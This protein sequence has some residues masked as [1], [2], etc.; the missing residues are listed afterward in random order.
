MLKD[1]REEALNQ[2]DEQYDNDFYEQAKEALMDVGLPEDEA[3]MQVEDF[4]M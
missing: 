2:L 3:E 1:L 4:I